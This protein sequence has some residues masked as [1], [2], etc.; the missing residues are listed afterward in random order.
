M[1]GESEVNQVSEIL[2]G[3]SVERG[4]SKWIEDRSN[5]HVD[6]TFNKLNILSMQLDLNSRLQVRIFIVPL[7]YFSKVLYF[8][9]IN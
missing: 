5:L 9:T 1:I 2:E 3:I 8:S 6:T 4:K 7:M